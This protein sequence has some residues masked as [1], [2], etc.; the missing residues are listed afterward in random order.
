MSKRIDS[1]NKLL[2]EIDEDSKLPDKISNIK[3]SRLKDDRGCS[4]CFPHGIETDNASSKKNNKSW[5]K[6]RKNKWK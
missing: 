5:K 1:V 4:Y 3:L 6:H 2:G